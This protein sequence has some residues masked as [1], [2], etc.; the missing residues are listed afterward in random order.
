MG[1]ESVTTERASRNRIRACACSP[2]FR[3]TWLSASFGE[4]FLL[5]LPWLAQL[6]GLP[7]GRVAA[8]E[9]HGCIGSRGGFLVSTGMPIPVLGESC[10]TSIKDFDIFPSHKKKKNVRNWYELLLVLASTDAFLA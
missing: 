2:A 7:N 5:F 1:V 4:G 9:S 10:T 6:V 8:D 3:S